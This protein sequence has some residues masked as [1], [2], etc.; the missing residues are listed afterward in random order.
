MRFE[1]GTVPAGFKVTSAPVF[2]GYVMP[3]VPN[4]YIIMM[5]SECGGQYNGYWKTESAPLHN[6]CGE[7]QRRRKAAQHSAQDWVLSP[8]IKQPACPGPLK[9]GP[10]IGLDMKRR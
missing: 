7:Q 10:G 3:T 4:G 6:Q 8:A 9:R 1:F 2:Y 5:R